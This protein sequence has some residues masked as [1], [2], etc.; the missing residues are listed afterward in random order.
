MAVSAGSSIVASEV[1]QRVTTSWGTSCSM[2]TNRIEFL[3]IINMNIAVVWIP[4]T[5]E[6]D[7]FWTWKDNNNYWTYTT[8]SNSVKI[9]N[10]AH[11][12]TRSKDSNGLNVLTVT[13]T[14]NTTIVIVAI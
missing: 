9:R 14:A 2:T 8:A 12:I 4:S 7:C 3:V 6:V 1:P 11:T 10:N 13:T 5:A